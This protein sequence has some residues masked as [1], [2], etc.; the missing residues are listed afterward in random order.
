MNLMHKPKNLWTP[1]TL[2]AMSFKQLMTLFAELPAPTLEEMDG[3]FAAELLAQ[4]SMAAYLLGQFTVGNPFMPG[5]WLCKAFQP[6]S[7]DRGLGYNRFD[8]LG[9]SVQRY[10]MQTL[11]APSRYDGKPAYT[12]VY[13]AFKSICGAIHMVDEVRRVRQGLYLGLG[14]WGFTDRQRRVPLPFVLSGP[15]APYAAYAGHVSQAK[16]GF[17]VYQEIPALQRKAHP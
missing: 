9:R 3:E 11:L 16:P 8:Q 17:D 14:T 2:H 10:P 12:L 5:R 6:T 15:V 7:A 4:P 13:A 1:S